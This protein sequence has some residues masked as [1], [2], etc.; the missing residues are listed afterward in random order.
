MPRQSDRQHSRCNSSKLSNDCG[1]SLSAT[2]RATKS[3]SSPPV[4]VQRKHGPPFGSLHRTAQL[5]FLSFLYCSYPLH[6]AQR[7]IVE[8]SLITRK[9]PT[10]K[11]ASKSAFYVGEFCAV[12]QHV[13]N[14][15]LL[16]RKTGLVFKHHANLIQSCTLRVCWWRSP[17]SAHRKL[18]QCAA[19]SSGNQ[20]RKRRPPSE[21]LHTMP[22][23]VTAMDAIWA[24]FPSNSTQHPTTLQVM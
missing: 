23:S 8:T 12:G 18:W 10:T 24:S 3:K 19:W 22:C 5:L 15:L 2:V 9:C 16:S 6:N 14:P 11:C 20:S 4:R 1:W 13:V 17:C 21:R 7:F